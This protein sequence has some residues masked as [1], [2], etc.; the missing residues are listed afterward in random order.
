MAVSVKKKT[1]Y[2]AVLK[3]R[4]KETYPLQKV[5]SNCRRKILTNT[6]FNVSSSC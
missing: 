2:I 1:L 6:V 5:I 3:K 4:K